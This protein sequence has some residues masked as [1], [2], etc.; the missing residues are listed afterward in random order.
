MPRSRI[1][2]RCCRASTRSPRNSSFS[3]YLRDVFTAAA[4]LELGEGQDSAGI[5]RA[6]EIVEA[7]R[8]AELQSAFGSE[9]L[10]P[11]AAVRPDDLLP[12]EIILY[13]VLLEDR[14]ELLY[15]TSSDGEGGPA[16][17]RRLPPN[18]AFNRAR[19]ADLVEQLV[20]AMRVGG[21][22][23]WQG[24]ARTL[25]DLLIAPIA[26]QLGPDAML[27]I[28]PDGPL[29]MLPFAAL[30]APDGRFLVEQTRLSLI[31][32]LAYSEPAGSRRAGRLDLVAASL[33]RR[34][35][36]PVGSFPALEG[37]GEEA[38]IAASFATRQQLLPDFTRAE[39]AGALDRGRVDVLHLAT[40]A[41]FNGRS[42][43]AFIVANGGVI[44]LSELR[45]LVAGS[46]TR[47]GTLDLIILSACETAVG[48]DE[49]SLGLAG[50]AV[51]A[52]A[53]SVIG[54]LWQV[55]DE[56]TAGL[57][58][59]FYRLYAEGLPRAEAL[60]EAQLV[61]VRSGGDMADP[62]IWASFALLGAWR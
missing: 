11:R 21:S 62:G 19:V 56:G 45:D 14:V 25:Y 29:R 1:S 61:L 28:V 60:R 30:V 12:G 10:P 7:F 5:R 36:L 18:R 38:R 42:D 33:E 20:L 50:A 31:P 8:Q 39:L 49:A 52:G 40:H 32:A 27:A 2:V 23:A 44:R 48:D 53:R 26:G 16:R 15:V 47:G 57:M 4:E 3:L 24:Q 17:Y 13:P 34:M 46:R 6:Q 37:T 58:R 35:D 55:S 54:S 9:C 22:G 59:E 51:Q 43:R 41:A